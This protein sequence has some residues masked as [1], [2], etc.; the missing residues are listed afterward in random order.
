M[1]SRIQTA[2]V[3]GIDG[4]NV[5]VEVDITRGL[6]GFHV[7]GLGDTAIKEAGQRVKSAVRNSGFDFPVSRI[8]V[9]LVPAYLHKKGSHYDLSMAMGILHSSGAIKGRHASQMLGSSGFLGELC[10]D[11]SISGVKGVL[12]MVRALAAEPSVS[13]V[14]LPKSNHAEGLLAARACGL[15]LV[16]VEHLREAVDYI[17]GLEPLPERDGE[18]RNPGIP[19]LAGPGTGG[20]VAADE[21]DFAQVKGHWDVKEALAVAVCGN[22]SILLMGPPGSGKT[23][24]ARRIPT[25]LPEMTAA[26]QLETTM[27]Y[28][29][30]GLLSEKNPLVQQRPFRMADYRASRA[31]LMGGGLVPYP[32]EASLAHNGVLFIDE[33]LELDR[34][35]IDAL[36]KPMEEEEVRMIRGGQLYT[37]PARFLLA[38]ASNPCRCG[39]YGDENHVCTCSRTQ[40]DQYQSRLSGPVADRIDMFVPV[41]PVNFKTLQEDEAGSS[42]RL[43]EKVLLGREMQK[44]RFAGCSISLNSQMEERHL[45]EFCPL[46]G[47]EMR[48]LESMVDRYHL[49]TRRYVKL[50]RVARTVADTAGSRELT[51][52]HLAAALR[53]IIQTVQGTGQTGE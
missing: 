15:R 13:Q 24:L 3:S 38:A 40:I 29:V 51:M 1:L 48:F 30:A 37:Y 22:H 49:S 11:G 28:S 47:E 33:F 31:G 17:C 5:I 50:M 42:E 25:I 46:G 7:V 14:F 41:Y 39:Y 18:I 45:K 34:N 8:V 9:N 52:Y 20:S 4:N 23:M 36:R 35:Q 32:G 44:E 43:R 53:Y 26:E 27:V 21:L 16:P 10:L 19:A 6:P 2:S 12:P